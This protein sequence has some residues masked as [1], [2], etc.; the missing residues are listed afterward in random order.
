MVIRRITCGDE[1]TDLAVSLVPGTSVRLPRVPGMPVQLQM[2]RT[3]RIDIVCPRSLARI[4]YGSDTLASGR[5][6]WAGA[7]PEMAEE[8]EQK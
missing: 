8:D 3:R 6:G 2:E 5:S 4:R 1:T 7:A